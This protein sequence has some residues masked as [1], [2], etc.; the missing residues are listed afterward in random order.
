[1]LFE[2]ISGTFKPAPREKVFDFA[3]C[4][5]PQIYHPFCVIAQ[6]SKEVLLG[7]TQYRYDPFH[8]LL[9]TVELPSVRRVVEA[10]KAR[11]YLSLCLVLPPTLVGSVM[12]EAGYVSPPRH[13][14]VRAI[15]V[16]PLDADLLDATVRLA[17]LVDSP[18]DAHI[19]MPLISREMI[20]RLLMSDQG[21]RLRHLALLGGFTPHITKAIQ[22]IRQD[23][24][25]SLRIEDLAANW[26]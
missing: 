6:G 21:G 3:V 19:L 22:R 25:Q 10:S 26:E 2:E 17:R 4:E 16:S 8:Y 15:D 18:G 13:L 1:M 20:Y 14:D 12:V 11:P 7:D 9:A 23:Y 24:D 5:L